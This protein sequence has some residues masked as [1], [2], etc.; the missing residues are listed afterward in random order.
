MTLHTIKTLYLSITNIEKIIISDLES[1]VY[2]EVLYMAAEKEEKKKKEYCT[3]KVA[4]WQSMS[5]VMEGA[6]GL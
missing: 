6:A 1:S 2:K 5:K 4:E 3:P